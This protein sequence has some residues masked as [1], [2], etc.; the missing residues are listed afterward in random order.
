MK[1]GKSP[2]KAKNL[3][4]PKKRKKRRTVAPR[5]E[6]AG[7]KFPKE[8]YDLISRLMNLE[9]PLRSFVIEVTRTLDK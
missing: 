4:V 7:G 1:R 8:V 5:A 2:I 9:T 3:P 6:H